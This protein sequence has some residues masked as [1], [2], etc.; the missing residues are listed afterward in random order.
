VRGVLEGFARSEQVRLKHRATLGARHPM[1]AGFAVKN[2]AV[3]DSRARLRR[4][5]AEREREHKPRRP[6]PTP[7]AKRGKPEEPGPDAA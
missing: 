1:I 4:W 5:L 2:L 6:R 3:A 7:R